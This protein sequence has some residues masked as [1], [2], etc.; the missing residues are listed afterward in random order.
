MVNAAVSGS[1]KLKYSEL[2]KNEL[3]NQTAWRSSLRSGRMQLP[4]VVMD[5]IGDVSADRVWLFEN[6]EATA[7]FDTGW[8]GY[9]LLEEERVQVYVEDYNDA[10]YQ[11]A[12][13]NNLIGTT[14]GVGA[15][16]TRVI[17][18]VFRWLRRWKAVTSVKGFVYR[19]HLSACQQRGVCYPGVSAETGLRFKI[20][21]NYYVVD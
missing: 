9:K 16:P 14:F 6:E 20:V 15:S 19:T 2:V 8:D 3:V 17:P 18:S 10:K 21:D 11:I 4:Y 5:V 13:V 7:G 1:V 12:T